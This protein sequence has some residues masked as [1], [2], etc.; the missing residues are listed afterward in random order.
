MLNRTYIHVLFD[1]VLLQIFRWYRLEEGNNWNLRYTWRTLTHI[2]RKWRNLIYGSWSYLDM[3][4]L[5]TNNSPSIDT[6][7]HLPPLPLVIDYSD[8]TRTVSQKDEDNIRFGLQQHGR[9]RRVVLR[10]P[11]SSLRM[12][13]EPMNNPFPRLRDLSL[14]STTV[15]KTNPMFPE[16]LQAPDLRRL[17]LHGITLSTE[18]PLLSSTIALSK[19]SLTCIGASSYFPP[20]H[21]VTQLQCLPHL[22]ELSID[23]AF[24]KSLPG[25]ERDR[26]LAPNPPMTLPA[27]RRFIFG[28]EDVY[29]D[30]LVAQI[31]T[32]LLEQ[33]TL[34]LLFDFTYTI[35]NLAEFICRDEGSQCIIAKVIFNRDTASIDV[36]HYEQQGIGKLSLRI[37][38]KP[39][40]WKID[41]ATQVCSALGKFLSVVEMLTIDLDVDGMPSDWENTLDSTVWHELLLPFVGVNKLR[42]GSSLTRELSKAL[43]SVS[44][45]LVPE[46]LPALQEFE[47]QLRIDHAKTAFSGFIKTR[48]SV[49]RPVRLLAPPVPLVEPETRRAAPSRRSLTSTVKQVLA[50]HPKYVAQFQLIG[51]T[52]SQLSID[53]EFS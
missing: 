26:L 15:E 41:S 1:D 28:G 8:R 2:C 17:S 20:E 33:L 10:A 18:S 43:E 31:N 23:F 46:L 14:S 39:F 42:I 24:S 12:W 37:N 7:I 21:L 44:G 3:C 6:L 49:G 53:L 52:P 51:C 13:L 40:D 22:E 16:T 11:Y 4:L 27:L 48:E 34:T 36:G 29:L 19:L 5:L 32:P 50:D 30:N 25:I 9:L 45:G 47:V 35:V 38:C